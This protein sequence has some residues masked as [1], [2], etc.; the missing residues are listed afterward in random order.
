[1]RYKSFRATGSLIF[2]GLVGCIPTAII[3]ISTIKTNQFHPVL[4]VLTIA[5]STPLWILFTRMFSSWVVIQSVGVANKFL[6]GKDIT[7]SWS[8]CQ[9]IGIGTFLRRQRIY[10]F[11]Y[12]SKET[13][14]YNQI[15]VG[16]MKK[17]TPNYIWIAFSKSA[18]TDILQYVPKEQIHNISLVE[19]MV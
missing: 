4:I 9:E 11:I 8:E 14:E 13:I 17:F 12:F 10:P 1:M 19:P 16:R 3:I 15:G 18:L 2:A 6:F 5:A 7:I